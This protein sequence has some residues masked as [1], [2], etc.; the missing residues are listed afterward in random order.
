ML[1]SR[2]R[3]LLMLNR[4]IIVLPQSENGAESRWTKEQQLMLD[5]LQIEENR[6]LPIKTFLKLV[7]LSRKTWYNALQDSAFVAAVEALGFRTRRFGAK[8]I[9]VTLAADPEEELQ[10]DVW[11]M[12]R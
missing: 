9:E 2:E 10:K 11:D 8:H 4:K 6:R 1:I 7:G 12:R 5:A 3:E